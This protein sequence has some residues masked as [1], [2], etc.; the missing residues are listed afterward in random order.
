MIFIR[1]WAIVSLLSLW[2]PIA[3]AELK[4]AKG[5]TIG[6][7]ELTGTPNGVLIR[8][9]LQ[10][11]PPGVHAIHIHAVGKCEA[12][13]F[14]SAGPHFNPTKA[15]HGYMTPRG[16]HAGDLPNLHVPAGGTLEVE[17]RAEHASIGGKED[18]LR[19]DREDPLLDGDGAALVL[20][21]AA[22]D[23]T[24]DPAGNAGARIAC[25]VIR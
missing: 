25:G 20:H 13:S 24:S 7:A 2:A 8:L 23:Y 16:P 15:P 1:G 5:Q 6:H 22:D 14:E 10:S 21:E 3:K 17:L 9:H 12:P 19:G 18:P 11:A 4:D